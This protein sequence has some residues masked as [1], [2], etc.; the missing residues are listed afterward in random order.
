MKKMFLCLGLALAT[1]ASAQVLTVKSVER[2]SV[3]T[4]DVRVAGVSADASF[5]L[6]TTNGN[7]GLKK[8][9]LATGEM[10]TL[11]TAQG[12][13]YNAEFA[14]DGQTVVYRERL[15]AK[16]K[17]FQTRLMKM[18]TTASK[19][20]MLVAPTR[21]LKK[22]CAGANINTERPVVS[23]EDRQLMVTIGTMTTQI[24]PLGTNK[25]YIWPSVSPDG[26][27]VLFY[28]AGTGAFVSD[29]MGNN[30]KFL[31]RDVRAPRWF[32]NQVVIGM[33][34]Q[35]DGEVTTSSSIVAVDLQGRTQV[36]TKGVNAMYPYAAAGKIFCTGFE[37]ETYM[38]TVE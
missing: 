13:G 31:G 33:N 24:S 26:T 28:V 25:S 15:M 2:L 29:L 34:D 16:D 5:L 38:I 27:R 12:A 3:P 22:V 23:I 20:M 9:C 21:S 10:T 8:Y 18:E 6:L 1:M 35:D 17:T 36:L 4:G 14:R 30:V 37:G 19:P 32:N 7:V 11:S